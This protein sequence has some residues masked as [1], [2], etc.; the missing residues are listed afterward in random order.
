[1]QKQKIITYLQLHLFELKYNFFILLITFFY[2]F[3]ISYYFSDQL[4]YLLVNIL[5]HKNML[6][7][8]IFTNITEIF[9]TNILI[10]FF[11][12]IFIT[13]QLSILLI[14]FFLLKGLYKFENFIFIKFYFF[15][16]IFNLFIINFIFTN[17]I[18]HIWNFLLNL[19]FSNLYLLTIYFE[20]K[21]N[22]YFDFIFSSFIYIFIIF[23][24]FFFLFFLIL[25][26][27]FQIK[28]IITLRKF[29]YLK[30]IL[31]SALITPPDIINFLLISLIFILFFEIFIFISIYL[32]KYNFN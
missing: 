4:I 21:I 6:K 1:M 22:N 16:L 28:I 15:F 25:N 27:I 17:I 30:I 24:Y 14:W 12:S 26:N 18:P 3:L 29:F 19:N 9:I 8:F 20:P 7:Y 10:A 13:I 23:I 31:L 5:L 32:N 2:L 11:I